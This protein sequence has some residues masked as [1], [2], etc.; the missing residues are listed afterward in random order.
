MRSLAAFVG[1]TL[2]TFAFGQ[3]I[4]QGVP[5]SYQIGYAANLNIGDAVMNLSNSGAAIDL[6]VALVGGAFPG[7]GSLC[8]NIYVFDPQEEE[9]ACCTCLTTLDGLYSLSVKSDLISDT[10]T[11]ATPTSVVIKAVS[12]LFVGICDPTNIDPFFLA[13]GTLLWGTTLEPA[14]SPGTYGV[15]PVGYKVGNLTE[16]ELSGM[17]QVCSFIQSNGTG[18]GVCNFCST[19]ALSG[20]KR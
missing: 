18:Y 11:P 4:N 15:V 20:A 17:T 13:P 9:V 7:A 19:G 8:A 1:A 16:S 10:L 6:A 14:S 3:V 12:T 5:D 2:S